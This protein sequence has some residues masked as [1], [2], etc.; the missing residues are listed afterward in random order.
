MKILYALAIF[1]IS[2]SFA[3]AVSFNCKKATTFAEKEICNDPLL[4]K[5]DDVLSENYK[6][7][8][9][10]NIGEG[11]KKDIKTTQKIW[12]A[13]RDKCT[14]KQCLVDIYRRRV[15]EVCDYPVITGVN[16]VCTLSDDIK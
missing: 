13:N 2:S 5:L 11:A 4:G 6:F 3:F 14:D 16:P 12:L 1:L 10:S 15:D 8:L 7:M 9:A